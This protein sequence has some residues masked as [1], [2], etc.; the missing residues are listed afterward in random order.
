MHIDR[1]RPKFWIDG[2]CSDELNITVQGF[3]AFTAA[4]PRVT[5]YS[6]PGRNGDLT[7]WDGSYKNV[8][9]EIKCFVAQTEGISDALAK[10][11]NLLA[12]GGYKKL[13]LSSDLGR[14]RLA[15]ITN[16]A[17]IDIRMGVIAPFVL[18]MDCKPQRF[19]DG[20]EVVQL[21]GTGGVLYNPTRF[22]AKPIMRCYF[23]D[24]T[25]G[26]TT[27]KIENTLGTETIN[28]GTSVAAG[29]T[30][31]DIDFEEKSIINSAGDALAITSA[32]QGVGLAGGDNTITVTTATG[33]DRFTQIDVTPRW[34]TL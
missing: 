6:I 34:W 12:I 4:E 19:F 18:K 24:A 29:A 17:E 11:N 25:T 5:V 1:M 32:F 20:E 23:S 21:S 26:A 8:V 9:G 15:R 10:I 22:T 7:Y 13:I 33:S 14:Y 28:L 3:P 27:L 31:I 2:I 16:A 30:W